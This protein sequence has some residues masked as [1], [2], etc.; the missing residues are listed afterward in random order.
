MSSSKIIYRIIDLKTGEAVGSYS[1][2]YHDE[3][4][5]NTAEEARTANVHGMFEDPLK[6]RIAKVRVTYEEVE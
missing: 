3:F 5:F 6:Y 1:R 2:A 4:D